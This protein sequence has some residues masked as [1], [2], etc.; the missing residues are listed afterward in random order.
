MR[1]YPSGDYFDGLI[2]NNKWIS[3]KGRMSF[4]DSTD[5]QIG[6]W[7]N[8]KLWIIN[9]IIHNIDESKIYKASQS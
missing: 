3:G 7:K 5:Y 2:L 6:E 9:K 4:K 1:T 8:S